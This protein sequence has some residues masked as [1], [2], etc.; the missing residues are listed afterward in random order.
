MRARTVDAAL[1]RA[2]RGVPAG[3]RGVECARD[4][5]R[6]ASEGVKRGGGRKIGPAR[7]LPS[8]RGGAVRVLEGCWKGVANARDAEKSARHALHYITMR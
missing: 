5:T 6:L 2:K 3:R 8:G 7:V 4:D 1:A